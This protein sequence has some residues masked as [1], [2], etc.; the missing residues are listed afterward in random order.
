MGTPVFV[1][2]KEHVFSYGHISPYMVY[3]CILHMFYLR[4]KKAVIAISHVLLEQFSMQQF[5]IMS[6]L[7]HHKN[8][9]TE[10]IST[11]PYRENN[12]TS[13]PLM[14]A[15]AQHRKAPKNNNS[16]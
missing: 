1:E 3:K 2:D 5:S 8:I 4:K 14:G 12:I 9:T 13:C 11:S 6:T 7:K 15:R 16:I 10:N